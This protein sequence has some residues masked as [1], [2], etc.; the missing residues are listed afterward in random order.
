[1]LLTLLVMAALFIR[2]KRLPENVSLNCEVAYNVGL[3][4]RNS[5]PE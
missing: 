2:P 1:M 5:S 3:N 4:Q